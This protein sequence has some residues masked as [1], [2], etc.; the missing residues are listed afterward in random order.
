MLNHAESPIRLESPI[1]PESPIR[2]SSRKRK[3]PTS[4]EDWL[5]QQEIE[6][7]PE[8]APENAHMTEYAANEPQ[9]FT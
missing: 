6:P 4:Y 9:L 5:Y 2:R 7:A 3:A 8:G 1:R